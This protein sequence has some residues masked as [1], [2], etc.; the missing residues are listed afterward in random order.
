MNP[1]Q[2]AQ[3]IKH[4]LEQ[5][6]WPASVNP[7]FGDRGQVRVV[8]DRLTEDTIPPAFPW[9]IVMM[10]SGEVDPDEPGL[11]NQRFTVVSAVEVAGDPFGEHAAIG[12]A[13][14][15]GGLIKSASRG[16]GEVAA[17]VRAACSTITGSDGSRVLL[18]ATS[19]GATQ[20]MARG[21][22]VVMDQL[23]LQAVCTSA[24]SYAP[25]Q[26]L[27]HEG[28]KWKWDGAH[29]ERRFDF[30]QYRLMRRLGATPSPNLSEGTALYTGTAREVTLVQS[31]G[32]TYTIFAIY[33]GRGAPFEGVSP[34]E[35]GSYR[36]V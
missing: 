8:A 20:T 34:P 5:A 30:V 36:T 25:P 16:I 10:D 27:R 29:C 23:T 7:V 19:I 32:Y 12:G 35:T 24:P 33:G 1:V 2:F 15:A 21:R 3:Q 28:G 13:I 22:H 4:R 18:S 17:Q 26:R 31:A 9:A 14:A 11:I 6:K